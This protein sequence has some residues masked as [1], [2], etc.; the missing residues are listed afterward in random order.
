M[1]APVDTVP[2]GVERGL[3]II[4]QVELEHFTA[5]PPTVTPFEAAELSWRVSGPDKPFSVLIDNQP[6]AKSGT[7]EFTL[8]EPRTFSLEARAFGAKKRLGTVQ[9]GFDGSGC[10][11]DVIPAAAVRD[12]VEQAV[13]AFVPTRGQVRRKDTPTVTLGAGRVSVSM[14]LAIEIPNFFDAD[15]TMDLE[16]LVGLSSART[17]RASF[18]S[19]DVDVRFHLLEHIASLGSGTIVQATAQ[20]VIEAM[21]RMFGPRLAGDFTRALVSAVD[22]F[23]SPGEDTVLGGIQLSQQGLAITCCQRPEGGRFTDL[24]STPVTVIDAVRRI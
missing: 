1:A 2:P 24:L 13:E 9:I 4:A 21:L 3:E 12:G 16:F 19:V 14:E 17:V 5:T 15:A 6:V 11:T 20:S 8:F 7:A 22:Q 10:R 23:C 18:R